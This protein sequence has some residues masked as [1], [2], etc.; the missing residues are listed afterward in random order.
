[1][2]P[3]LSTGIVAA[4]LVSSVPAWAQAPHEPPRFEIA[5]APLDEALTAFAQQSGLQIILDA[6]AAEG[7]R[8]SGLS[9]TYTAEAAIA[10]LLA[11][12]PFRAEWL[13][14][15]TVAIRLVAEAAAYASPIADSQRESLV[16]RLA[17]AQPAE[18]SSSSEPPL[19]P[20][21]RGVNSELL[22]EVVVTGSHIARS[23]FD[24]PV[25][26]VA[27]DEKAI[28][29]SGFTNVTDILARMP[30][31]G[32]GSNPNNTTFSQSDVG[33]SFADLRGLGLGRTL[34]L[35]N[36]RRR[37]PGSDNSAAV[38]LS[39]IP[40]SMV[41]RIEVTT[42][43]AAAVY[44]ADA[45][46]GVLN[47]ILKRD[48][49]GLQLEGRVHQPGYDGGSGH[50]LSLAG[51]TPFSSDRGSLAFTLSYSQEDPIKASQLPWVKRNGTPTWV[52][53]PADTGPNDGI[54]DLISIDDMR[55][56]FLSYGG[57]FNVGGTMYTVDPGL[58]PI[59]NDRVVS[60]LG[61]G[62]DG[63]NPT[64]INT[65]RAGSE[66][67]TGLL[68]VKYRINDDVRLFADAD[69]GSAR[70]NASWAPA[71]NFGVPLSRDNALLPADVAALMDA[72]GLTQIFVSK[73]HLD[74]G[75]RHDTS[76]RNTYTAVL[77][78]E[79]ELR[80]G[81][82][83][84]AF[85]QYGSFDR[86]FRGEN[87]QVTG[88]FLNAIDAITD[89]Q[90]G[91]PVCRSASARDAGCVPISL[92][93]R[94]VPSAEALSYV[95]HTLIRDLRNTQKVAGAQL[96]GDL[97]TLPAG[98]VQLAS[99]FEYREE[100]LSTRD[101][102]AEMM[103][104]INQ[105]L[106]FQ[107]IDAGFSVKEGFAE[108]VVPVI[109]DKPLLKKLSFEGAARY[110]SYDTI[111]DATTWKLG[112]I[113]APVR[114]FRFRVMRADS[115]RAPNLFELFNPGV[116]GYGTNF[117][118]CSAENID[119]GPASRVANCRA[120]G[121]PD[122]WMTPRPGLGANTRT[123]G[124]PDLDP[125][126]SRSWTIGGVFT[127]RFA[128]TLS[129]SIDYWKVDIEEAVNTLDS[130]T[131]VT[132]CY[133]SATLDNPF[134]PFISRGTALSP[135]EISLIDVTQ[136][137]VGRLSSDGVDFAAAY[138][139]DV[140]N[141]NARWPGS[142]SVSLAG[143]YL[144]SLEE[145]VEASDPTTLV[146][147]AGEVEH[148]KWRANLYME[149]DNG[150]LSINW[151]LRYVGA[152]DFDVQAPELYGPSGVKSRIYTDLVGTYRWGRV[153]AQ[154]GVNN[155]LDTEPPFI[156]GLSSGFYDRMGRMVFGGVTVRL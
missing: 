132:R 46:S 156:A 51:G 48:F 136:V 155:L 57:S 53:N 122:G 15:H 85:Y 87:Y 91:Q 84:Q 134:C 107:P 20:E 95:Q 75:L 112:A 127:P 19:G 4:L 109:A 39:T 23:A 73:M 5:A 150:P 104:L 128:P 90:S 149:Y 58:R 14:G 126:T 80:H 2:N 6:K 105:G 28:Q 34:T 70:A 59:H 139:F 52:G 142:L 45:V 74:S 113:W 140:A 38:D 118:P 3:I 86:A 147:S 16:L 7:I 133:D 124:N 25:P 81:W 26:V 121:V 96:T 17:Q 62:G 130:L 89:P 98:P 92:L 79:G 50:T 47:I 69:F 144:R 41:E 35:V 22:D 115:V 61:I 27:M 42:G 37:V 94:D 67:Y 72:N 120:A 101:D 137:N 123:G 78:F 64:E 151:G 141:L 153:E 9:G 145:L 106:G 36:G 97:L 63:F 119:Q 54:A 11:Q 114:D 40:A 56:P 143:T 24:T 110:S 83:W 99:G 31:L 82:N 30:A 129:V 154:I 68:S 65:F 13:D 111:G 93:G 76:R 18:S 21:A 88:N 43:G 116:I 60:G 49:D 131:I 148:P 135:S 71:L 138:S 55:L 152:S 44:G 103:G 146:V 77:G 100:T 33:A 102:G 1:M 125:E 117:D 10:K 108:L 29:R 12:T 8:S 32:T 66:S